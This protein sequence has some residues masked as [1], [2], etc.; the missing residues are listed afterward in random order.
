MI[1]PVHAFFALIVYYMNLRCHA[2]HL[3]K[4]LLAESPSEPRQ[5][6]NF[7]QFD[8]NIGSVNDVAGRGWRA[9]K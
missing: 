8:Q 1:N 9:C 4:N 3:L 5:H 7:G 6:D 2:L